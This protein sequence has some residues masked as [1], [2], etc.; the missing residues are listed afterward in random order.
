LLLTQY[1]KKKTLIII[2]GLITLSKKFELFGYYKNQTFFDRYGA[3]NDEHP[4]FF[5]G[6]IFFYF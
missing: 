3:T 5:F 6:K 1:K 4:F 2:I